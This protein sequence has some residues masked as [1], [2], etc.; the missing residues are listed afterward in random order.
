M[1]IE[2]NRLLYQNQELREANESLLA[3]SQAQLLV[4]QEYE[5]RLARQER[6]IRNLLWNCLVL[7]VALIIV[8]AVALKGGC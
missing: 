5:H 1:L 7:I 4:I 3:T 8:G 6:R 2:Q